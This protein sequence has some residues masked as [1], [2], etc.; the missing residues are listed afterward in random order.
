MCIRDSTYIGSEHL[1]LGILEEG[2]GVAASVLTEKGITAEQVVE[3]LQ[4]VIG[5]GPVSYTH[6]SGPI[7]DQ[8]TPKARKQMP[9]KQET[10]AMSM[11]SLDCL[12]FCS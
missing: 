10:A 11:T 6:L 9:Q 3:R 12:R 2:T 1:L 5:Q 8:M 7:T 4:A